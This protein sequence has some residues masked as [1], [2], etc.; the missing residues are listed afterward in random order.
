[1]CSSI[2]LTEDVVQFGAVVKLA[3]KYRD[4]QKAWKL[5]TLVIVGHCRILR[6]VDCEFLYNLASRTNLVH[7]LFF[8]MFITFLYILRA[9]M[10]PSSGENTVPM[11][12][13]A[14]VT[15]YEWLSGMI[16]IP[17]IHIVTNTRCLIGTVFSPDD[18][19]IIARNM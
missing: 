19:H 4:L 17:V 9:N 7:T 2:N 8:N 6:F 16:C 3:I 11:R 5:F 12:H 10:C 1:V 15:L 13:L 18:R 14:F